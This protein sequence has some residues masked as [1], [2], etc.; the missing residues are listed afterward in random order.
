MYGPKFE[1][2]SA[3]EI[4]RSFRLGL[5]AVVLSTAVVFMFGYFVGVG[6]H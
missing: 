1:F 2:K 3:D 4:V 6:G 5:I